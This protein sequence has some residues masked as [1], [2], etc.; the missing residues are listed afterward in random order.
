MEQTMHDNLEETINFMINP[1]D[2]LTQQIQ[3]VMSIEEILKKESENESMS[4][5]D[6][7]KKNRTSKCK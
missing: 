1:E 3:Q 6:S 4:L 5:P 7:T 2:M